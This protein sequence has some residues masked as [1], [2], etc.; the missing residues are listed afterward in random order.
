MVGPLGA[1]TVDVTV[2]IAL[3]EAK[4]AP[5]EEHSLGVRTHSCHPE[6]H[7]AEFGHP[8]LQANLQPTFAAWD[9]KAASAWQRILDTLDQAWQLT[10][11]EETFVL[12]HES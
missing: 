2:A 9:V 5:T 1:V 11:C 8:G 4:N 3:G 6:Q 10:W 7:E 12:G